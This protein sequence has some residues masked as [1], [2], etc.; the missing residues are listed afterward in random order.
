MTTTRRS[1]LPASSPSRIPGSMQ[2]FA[3]G[4]VIRRDDP[5]RGP[6]IGSYCRQY[7]LH[8]SPKRKRPR[9]IEPAPRDRSCGSMCRW[10]ALRTRVLDAVVGRGAPAELVAEGLVEAAAGD[11]D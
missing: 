5:V 8:R 2:C 3:I 4:Q 1:A 6:A 11:L 7:A 9:P 10:A